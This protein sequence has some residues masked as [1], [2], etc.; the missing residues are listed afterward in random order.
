MFKNSR[1]KSYFS[2]YDKLDKELKNI[3]LESIRRF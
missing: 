3:H 2:G 1:K